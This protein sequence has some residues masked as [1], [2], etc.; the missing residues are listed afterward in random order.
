M[1]DFFLIIM[2]HVFLLL[3]IPDHFV[4]DARLCD[5]HLVSGWIFCIPADIPKLHSGTY[6]SYLGT[7][8]AFGVLL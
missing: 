6:L 1:I 7:V 5:F 8:S 4:L 3:C 2:V